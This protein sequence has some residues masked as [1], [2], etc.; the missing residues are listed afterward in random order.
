M[1]IASLNL[2]ALS[3]FSHPLHALARWLQ[4]A[5]H[6]IRNGSD[7]RPRSCKA[8]LPSSAAPAWPAAP[9]A[10]VDDNLPADAAVRSS[11]SH[12]G[13]RHPQPR[14]VVRVLRTTASG[15]DAGRLVISG[16][17]ADVCAELDRLAAC[18]T[19]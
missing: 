10:P 13:V 8:P 2:S 5:L 16:R 18:E 14:R 3:T 19:A 11:T 15:S 9:C 4:P 7:N 12:T 6:G 1:R 17:M